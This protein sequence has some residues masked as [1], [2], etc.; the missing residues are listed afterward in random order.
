MEINVSKVEKFNAR[1]C[2]DKADEHINE[3]LTLKGLFSFNDERVNEET[4]DVENITVNCL[5]T[6]DCVIAT[7]SIPFNKSIETLVDTFSEDEIIGL[8][9]MIVERKSKSGNKFYQLAVIG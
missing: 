8:N 1:N 3:E 4:G 9:V 7:P 5:I 6:E 2:A